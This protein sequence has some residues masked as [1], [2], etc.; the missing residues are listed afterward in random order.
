MVTIRLTGGG[1]LDGQSWEATPEELADDLP[2]AYL[3][4]DGPM[5]PDVDPAM[6][7]AYEARPG[8][9]PTVWWWQGWVP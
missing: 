2:G 8:E 4:V 3:I 6:R 9:D 7:A 5:A 1:P